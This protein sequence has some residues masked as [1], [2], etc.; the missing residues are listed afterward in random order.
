MG[1]SNKNILWVDDKIFNK[2]WEN[3][4]IME[5]AALKDPLINIIPKV[6]T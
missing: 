1:Q 5:R 3:K 2:E 6:S 4:G